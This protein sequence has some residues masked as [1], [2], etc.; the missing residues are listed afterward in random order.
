MQ[1]VKEL[2]IIGGF[3]D[4]IK[5]ITVRLMCIGVTE[6]SKFAITAEGELESAGGSVSRWSHF[7][8]RCLHDLP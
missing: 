1:Y 8:K 6:G 5:K 3:G 2:N 7:G 4:E